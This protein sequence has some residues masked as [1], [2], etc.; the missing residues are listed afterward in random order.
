[1]QQEI[2]VG[3]AAASIKDSGAALTAD[4]SR[5]EHRRTGH[6]YISLWQHQ[7]PTLTSQRQSIISVQVLCSNC[8]SN[9]QE[10]S[11][12]FSGIVQVMYRYCAG[13]VQVLY[14]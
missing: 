1:M 9:V 14:R 7:F 8:T 4:W 11:R 10:L 3:T 2:F 5:V 6:I 12:Y 13:I